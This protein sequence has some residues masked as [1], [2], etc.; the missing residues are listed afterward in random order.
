MT[1]EMLLKDMVNDIVEVNVVNE[2]IEKVEN[3]KIKANRKKVTLL[4][5][6]PV[7]KDLVYKKQIEEVRNDLEILLNEYKDTFTKSIRYL[8]KKEQELVKQFVKEKTSEELVFTVK[9]QKNPFWKKENLVFADNYKSKNNEKLAA[10]VKEN[11]SW[12]SQ[13]NEDEIQMVSL[14]I[15][16]KST[17]EI[18]E[19]FKVNKDKIYTLLFRN[20]S[21]SVLNRLGA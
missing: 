4:E 19:I 12:K 9:K 1:N 13:L 3:E 21:K 17:I 20:N 8:P 7:L 11:T 6:Y 18:G 16:D 10:I 15:Q 5:L 2:L 14:A